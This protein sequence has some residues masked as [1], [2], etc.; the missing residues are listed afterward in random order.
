MNTSLEGGGDSSGA[1]YDV[2]PPSQES[3]F[4]I[5]DG[6]E[7]W[8]AG[9]GDES[10]EISEHS[11]E[12]TDPLHGADDPREF[13]GR[14]PHEYTETSNDAWAI[15]EFQHP[16]KTV[17]AINPRYDEGTEY[18]MNCADCSRTFEASWR[19]K[20]MEAAGRTGSEGESPEYLEEWAHE[21]LRKVSPDGLRS[22]LERGGHGSS[23]I[24]GTQYFAKD[25]RGGHA[26]N[27]VNHQG[28]ILTVD[29]QEG[30]CVPMSAEIHHKFDRFEGNAHSAMAWD[31]HGRSLL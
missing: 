31:S 18:R 5:V 14:R 16:N 25:T 23:A 8:D 3:S 12:G 6:M 27:V 4:T 11:Q 7:S 2:P 19:G 9:E 22:A 17:E 15:K 10:R 30:T 13:R 29:G 20:E 21:D 1:Q 26:Y 28:E 24:V